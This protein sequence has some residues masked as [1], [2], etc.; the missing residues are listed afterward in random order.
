MR[1]DIIRKIDQEKLIA[2]VRG[3]APESCVKVADALYEGGFR[4]MEVTFNLKDPASW[5]QTAA[6]IAACGEK[7]AGRMEIGAGTV[8]SVELCE[9]AAAAGA[10]FI[11]S[12]DTNPA[13][14]KRTIE[15]G[16][17]SL[18]GALTPSEILTAHFAGA[19]YVKLFPIS[20]MGPKYA[21]AVM[22]PI[23]NV[24]MLAV[25]GVNE[26]NL[27][28]YLDLGLAGAGIGGNLVNKKWIE[29]GEFEK[30]TEVARQMVAIAKSK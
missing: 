17:V 19:D 13:V 9:L 7:Y 24:K 21:K 25:G 16:M 3:I 11:V 26:N 22:A 20:D 18:P 30:I 28:E 27:K 5:K 23:S 14:I 4:L 2:I 8:V 29:A 12:P 6:A 1:E 15:L 10:K